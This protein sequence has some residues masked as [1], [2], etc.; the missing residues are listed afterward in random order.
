MVRHPCPDPIDEP[1]P[2]PFPCRYTMAGRQT[3]AAWLYSERQA[4]GV[5]FPV[6]PSGPSDLT[7]KKPKTSSMGEVTD[8]NMFTSI[9]PSSNQ[10][11]TRYPNSMPFTQQTCVVIVCLD[12]LFLISVQIAISHFRI[13]FNTVIDALI[14]AIETQHTYLFSK[15]TW[16]HR[17]VILTDGESPIKLGEWENTAQAVN[18]CNLFLTVMYVSI[19][20][21]YPSPDVHLILVGLTSMKIPMN[22]SMCSR[23]SP[24]SR[25]QFHHGLHQ[26]HCL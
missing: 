13:P 23:T 19:L 17:I 12:E 9:P 16:M 14:V 7:M 8:M 10:T 4:H 15:K 21:T 22:F 5:V 11:R 3:S 24:T 6:I 20:C 25:Y 18:D 1:P 26:S 2:I